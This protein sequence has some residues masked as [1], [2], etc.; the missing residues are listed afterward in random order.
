MLY[1]YM[2]YSSM[3]CK[4]TEVA[5]LAGHTHTQLPMCFLPTNTALELALKPPEHRILEREGTCDS[6]LLKNP[7]HGRNS[8]EQLMI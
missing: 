2:I 5:Q 6:M 8:H 4:T 3:S 1:E 7:R